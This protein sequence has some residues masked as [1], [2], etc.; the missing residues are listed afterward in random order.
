M[1]TIFEY[2]LIKHISI[3]YVN[4]MLLAFHLHPRKPIETMKT[5]NNLHIVLFKQFSK[6]VEIYL[7]S[8][9]DNI[10]LTYNFRNT[11]KIPDLITALNELIDVEIG[12]LA[13]P[14][15]PA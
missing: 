12:D 11:S 2:N 8:N 14:E 5:H 6:K 7:M 9:I 4:K 10:K 1:N 13:L 15:P 3:D